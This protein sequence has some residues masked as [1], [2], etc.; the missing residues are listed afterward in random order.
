MNNLL[1]RV[2][3]LQELTRVNKLNK[4]VEKRM[5]VEINTEIES[6]FEAYTRAQHGVTVAVFDYWLS[7]GRAV[8]KGE[9]ARKING[10]NVFHITQTSSI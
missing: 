3:Q 2:T 5:T 9:K 10:I 1:Q 8:R 6:D 4:A 7:A